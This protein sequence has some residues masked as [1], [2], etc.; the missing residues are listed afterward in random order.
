M[1]FFKK[2]K[3]YIYLFKIPHIETV[4][5]INRIIFN[6]RPKAPL[7]LSSLKYSVEV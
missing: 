4:K 7:V 6:I 2:K 3:I 5:I 1:I